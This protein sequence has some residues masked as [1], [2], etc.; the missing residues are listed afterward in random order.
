M[1]FSSFNSWALRQLLG[2]ARYEII[3]TFLQGPFGILL[4]LM[5]SG[6]V[7]GGVEKLNAATQQVE[8]VARGY[9]ITIK[10]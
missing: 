9:G 8:E 4:D 6:K 7:S 2:R 5:L 3:M 10:P 1:K